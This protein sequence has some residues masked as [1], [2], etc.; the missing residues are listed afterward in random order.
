MEPLLPEARIVNESPS[1]EN[2][3]TVSWTAP[4]NQNFLMGYRVR[5]T[6]GSARSRRQTSSVEVSAGTTSTPLPFTAFTSYTVDVDAIYTP[7]PDGNR[8]FIILLPSTTFTTPQRR[9]KLGSF[10]KFF[11][12]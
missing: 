8:E 1:V 7:P 6:T 10:G 9:K 4:P 2:R 11:V 3:L 5:Y 12:S